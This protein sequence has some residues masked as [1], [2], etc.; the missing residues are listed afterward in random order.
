[1]KLRYGIIVTDHKRCRYVIGRAETIDHPLVFLRKWSGD[2]EDRYD[3]CF[4]LYHS[5][6][7][8]DEADEILG[9]LRNGENRK[10]NTMLKRCF[11]PEGILCE[12]VGEIRLD[13]AVPDDWYDAWKK[14]EGPITFPRD[15]PGCYEADVE[16]LD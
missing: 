16:E 5:A 1:M 9:L 12:S 13:D 2:S 10:A 11:K 8:A 3:A 14:M 4:S 15:F 6:L 7:T